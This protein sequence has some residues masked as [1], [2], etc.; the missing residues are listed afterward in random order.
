MTEKVTLRLRHAAVIMSVLSTLGMAGEVQAATSNSSMAVSANVQATCAI[1]ANPLA[2]GTYSSNQLDAATTI[3]VNCTNTTT[4]SVSL[5]TGSGT[6]ATV[7]QRKMSNGAQ[8]LTYTVYS[9]AARSTLWGSTINTNT[10]AGTG[11]GSS[12][13]LNVY[14][15]IPAG[16]LPTPGAYSDTLTATITY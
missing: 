6:G 8:T 11:T 10:V 14:G 3:G 1:A 5:D 12:Q 7:A 13:S 15:R 2:F 9:D 4:Y 16:Q